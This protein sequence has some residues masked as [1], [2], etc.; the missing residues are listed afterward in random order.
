[1]ADKKPKPDNN[2]NTDHQQNHRENLAADYGWSL[3][4]LNSHPELKSL[5]DQAVKQSWTPTRFIAELRDTKW[6]KNTSSTMRQYLVNRQTDPA[7]WQADLDR[8]KAHISQTYGNLFGNDVSDKQV[9]RWAQHAMMNGWT[10]E[11]VTDHIVNSVNVRKVYAQRNLGG[12][13]AQIKSQLQQLRAAY[14]VH[15]SPKWASQQMA[16]ILAGN[17]TVDGAA[18]YLKELAK[19]KYTGFADQ[20]DGGKTMDQIADPYVQSMSSLLELNPNQLG[21]QSNLVQRALTRR[22]DGK[23]DPMSMSQFEDFVRKDPRFMFTDQAKQQF[24]D[25]AHN[26]LD[27]WGLI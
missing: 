6:F 8:M 14:G 11:Q 16:D 23:P 1:M 25:V 4:F 2:G 5:F 22:V 12:T 10:D 7:S 20:L 15:M 24:S 17:D 27:T 26:L 13:A 3:A 19:S 21:L 9:E 18:N